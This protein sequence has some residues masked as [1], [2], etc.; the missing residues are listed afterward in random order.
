[1]DIDA[2]EKALLSNNSIAL[3]NNQ[4]NEIWYRFYR[5]YSEYMTKDVRVLSYLVIT[6]TR[7]LLHS[8]LIY[9]CVVII[10]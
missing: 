7:K 6:E 3:T 9:K 2:T 8:L 5:P 1:M 10:E 4:I